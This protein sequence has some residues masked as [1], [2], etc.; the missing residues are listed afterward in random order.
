[1]LVGGDDI[2]YIANGNKVS[3]Y[4]RLTN[5]GVLSAIDL[6]EDAVVTDIEWN[7]KKLIIT[8]D[9][10]NLT[11]S[12]R[13]LQ[14]VFIWN[15]IDDSWDDDVPQVRRSGAMF[16]KGGVTFI[17]YQDITSDGQGRLG[18]LNGNQITELCQWNG[19]LPLFYQVDEKDGFICWVSRVGSEDL[20]FCWGSG[21]PKLPT[22]LFQLMRGHHSY[23]G[24]IGLPFGSLL[25]A[26][27]NGSAG[28]DN[29]KVNLSKEAGYDYDS[30]W[31]GMDFGISLDEKNAVIRKL[32]IDTNQI[33]TGAET[34]LK[35]RNSAGTQLFRGTL[36]FARFGRKT[37]KIY[38]MA[39][40]AEDFRL[41]IDNRSGFSSTTTIVLIKK[42]IVSGYSVR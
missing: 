32:T 38:T 20:I 21:D 14:R 8:V 42:A 25:V 3:S 19:T 13:T 30:Y 34:I 2:L 29:V 11:G 10:P 24:A 35:L 17:F 15:T 4:D 6:N 12:N 36:S 5:I 23:M 28:G 18:Y 37:K 22:R 16:T 33:Q 40:R 7:S 9:W 31:Y 26:S 27:E 39:K 41:E 1:M